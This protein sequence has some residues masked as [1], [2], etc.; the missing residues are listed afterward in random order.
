LLGI[1]KVAL[2]AAAVIGL[3]LVPVAGARGGPTFRFVD[4]EFGPPFDAGF[5]GKDCPTRLTCD[6]HVS[7]DRDAGSLA[8]ATKVQPNPGS[9]TGAGLASAWSQVQAWVSS[10]Q[11]VPGLRVTV[12]LR[13]LAG[14]TV[15]TQHPSSNSSAG[16]SL[17]VFQFRCDKCS[18]FKYVPVLTASSLDSLPST[19]NADV[20]VQIVVDL[21]NPDGGPLAAGTF[22]VAPTLW[23]NV[24]HTQLPTIG[25][26]EA[27]ATAVVDKMKTEVLPA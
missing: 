12:D 26:A 18:A 19:L 7:H 21:R 6:Q 13:L 14:S 22:G 11:P 9:P 4:S 27:K 17:L 2:V 20:P 23:T 16:V 24:G 15:A 5:A 25:T 10:S 1:R 3:L 8:S